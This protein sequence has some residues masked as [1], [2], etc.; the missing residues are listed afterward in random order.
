M[1]TDNAVNVALTKKILDD[2]R[3]FVV[4]DDM[5]RGRDGTV[6]WTQALAS[7]NIPDVIL[8]RTESGDFFWY[9]DMKYA[10]SDVFAVTAFLAAWNRE[11]G[12]AS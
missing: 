10:T 2:T 6:R 9:N 11:H 5:S 7:P 8:G 12:H 4:D 3:W 1:S